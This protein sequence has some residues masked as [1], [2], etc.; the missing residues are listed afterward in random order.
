MMRCRTSL[1]GTTYLGDSIIG[2]VN[3]LQTFLT[4][5]ADSNIS[6]LD[7]ADI[8]GTITDRECHCTEA[9]FDEFDN[10]SFLKRGD[11]TANDAFASSPEVQQQSLAL[12]VNKSLGQA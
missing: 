7:H 9:V 4:A 8:I 12:I 6:S 3:S 5:N 11:A 2:R 1:G 10:K